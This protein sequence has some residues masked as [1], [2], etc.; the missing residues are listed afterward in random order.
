MSLVCTRML[1]GFGFTMN[2]IFGKIARTLHEKKGN[3]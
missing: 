1:P 3:G 2:Q